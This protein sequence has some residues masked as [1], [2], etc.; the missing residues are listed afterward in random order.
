[1]VISSKGGLSS[2]ALVLVV[3][4]GLPS[5]T[6]KPQTLSPPP[7]GGDT[8]VSFAVDVRPLFNQYGCASANCHGAS[9]GQSNYSVLT[10][11][12]V[13]TPGVQ[14]GGRGTF[15]VLAGKPDSS[16]MVWKLEGRQGIQGVRMPFNQPPMA[17]ADIATIRT[18]IEQGALDN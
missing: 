2:F 17:A 8:P 14:A 4:L 7:D 1:M 16:Y 9:P 6:E 11:L 12:S 18:W 13:R 5:C 3:L 15:P 10:Y